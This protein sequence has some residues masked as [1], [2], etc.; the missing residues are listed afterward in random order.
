[1]LDFVAI[2]FETANEKRFSPC[3]VGLSVIRDGKV[4][5]SFY[6]LIKP[7]ECRFTNTW[8]HG[9]TAE[10]VLSEPD[11]PEIW[12]H[13]L[14]RIDGL[15]AIAHYAQFDMSVIR[16]TLTEYE[17]PF[18]TF[19]YSCSQIVAKSV[20]AGLANYSLPTVA[21][22]LGIEFQHHHALEDAN[23]CAQIVCHACKE[24]EVSSL[25]DLLA[26][27]EL[28]HGQIHESGQCFTPG[29]RSRAIKKCKTGK[30]PRD[31]ADI[32]A[33]FP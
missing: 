27:L 19:Q 4:V 13:L 5:D 12:P 33:L 11:F 21:S 22:I 29:S 3:S 23:A 30:S 9:I 14:K 31:R 6:A 32:A 18:P 8:I 15:P 28:R 17:I 16:H 7:K 24:K 25:D 1:M 2:D 26:N 20:W 10:D